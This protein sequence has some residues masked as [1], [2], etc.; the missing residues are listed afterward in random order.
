MEQ[1]IYKALMVK[2]ST[3][4]NVVVAAKKEVLTVDQF[5]NKLLKKYEKDNS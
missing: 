5:I 2:N 3:H 4:T 1:N